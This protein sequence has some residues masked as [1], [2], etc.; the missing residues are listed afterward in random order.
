MFQILT[1]GSII[2]ARGDTLKSPLKISKDTG[3]NK[4]DY[5]LTEYDKVYFAIIQQGST[6]ENAIVK[7]VYDFNSEKDNFGNIYL[8]LNP[9]D[10]EMLCTGLY[11]Y[12]VKLVT[13]IG[14]AVEVNTVIP[15]RDFTIV[16]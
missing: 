16:N 6:F 15:E 9:K 8:K 1:N 10:T 4:H 11:K 2:M 12:T 14:D 7:K 13:T 5:A 3:I